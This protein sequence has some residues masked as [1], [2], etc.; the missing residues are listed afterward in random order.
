MSDIFNALLPV[1]EF[2]LFVE[3][4]VAVVAIV[5]VEPLIV[6]APVQ[7]NVGN[8]P[9]DMLCGSERFPHY[10]LVDVAEGDVM[11]RELRQRVSIIPTGVAHFDHPRI[12][13]EL[14]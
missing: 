7:A 9:S 10:R 8:R 3:V 14:T 11:A 1:L 6:I 12:F 5:G 4:V 2:A 13:D